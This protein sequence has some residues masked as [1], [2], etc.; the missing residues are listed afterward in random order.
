M[1]REQISTP[2][3]SFRIFKSYNKIYL[4][5]K[6]NIYQ[7][8]MH[9]D[10]ISHFFQQFLPFTYILK[11]DTKKTVFRYSP[12]CLITYIT[13]SL[14]LSSSDFGYPEF[15]EKCVGRQVEQGF[16]SFFAKF[17]AINENK[18]CST[19]LQPFSTWYC[20]AGTRN[21]PIRYLPIL[22]LT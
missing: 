15:A 16:S 7:V 14:Q 12:I 5:V 9:A 18:P 22:P 11:S 6:C 10:G 3:P 13:T 20:T 4:K 8:C 1:C 19:C 2:A 21:P 17:L